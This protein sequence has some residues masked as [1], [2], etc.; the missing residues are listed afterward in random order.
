[1]KKRYY[2]AYGSNLSVEQMAQRCPDAKV[3]G[4]AAIQDWKLVFRV[5]ATVEP[6][7][8]R[9]VPVLIWEISE[10]DERH[11]DVYEGYPSY[12]FK[13]DL[14]LTMTDLNGRNPRTVTAMV[15]IMA[16]GHK[17][18]MPMK[19]YVDVLAE[20]YERFGFDMNILRRALKETSEAEEAERYD[21]SRSEDC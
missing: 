17:V 13:R 18:R 15:Y 14:E 7:E 12:Y 10:R 2:I 4:M 9:V 5:H 21:F 20:G 6:A 3:V 1:M 16:D 8:G 11:L 19:G